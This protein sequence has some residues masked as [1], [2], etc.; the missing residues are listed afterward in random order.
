MKPAERGEVVVHLLPGSGGLG[1]AALPDD[2]LRVVGRR[3]RLLD[4][5]VVALGVLH[6]ER[7]DEAEHP[8]HNRRGR[9]ILVGV[10]RPVGCHA[11]GSFF[12]LNFIFYGQR[13]WFNHC[14][15]KQNFDNELLLS[16]SG[17]FFTLKFIFAS[18]SLLW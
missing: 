5:V 13:V 1:V 6:T 16:I 3:R 18:N 12:S 14:E 11:L 9:T 4:V 15:Q 8:G 2:D 7:L 10:F 17:F